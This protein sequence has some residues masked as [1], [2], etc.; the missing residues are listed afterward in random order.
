M[1]FMR[2]AT[3]WMFFDRAVRSL[4]VDDGIRVYEVHPELLFGPLAI[5]AAAPIAALPGS[6]EE[7][8][9]M[10]FGQLVGLAV[11]AGLIALI[12][13]RH[14]DAT[15]SAEVRRSVLFAGVVFLVAWTRLSLRS[16]HLD[17]EIALAAI[18]WALVSVARRRPDATVVLVAIA[19]AVKPWGL[20]AVPLVLVAGTRRRLLRLALVG[21]AV[22]L[23]WAPFVLGAPDTVSS[24]G[25]F[26][27]PVEATSGIATLGFDAA[28][29]PD[30]ARP[31]QLVGGFLLAALAVKRGRWLAAPMVGI[32]VR[33][34][35]DPAT[36][37]YYV[38]G[39]VLAVMAW[40]L[41][42]DAR[43]V[44]WRSV[45]VLVVLEATSG[46]GPALPLGIVRL[47]LLALVAAVG[48]L[49]TERS[50]SERAYAHEPA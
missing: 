8:A 42:R 6:L 18:V 50:D 37:Y 27:S 47:G 9:A 12:R 26:D 30:W 4:F 43:M 39:L 34:A 44:P 14:P 38:I 46:S 24:L 22:A 28:V 48:L 20:V 35:F 23:T 7:L 49:A 29:T 40:E 41:G 33:L 36:H 2:H 32:A 3:S 45:I 15:D 19:A 5:L 17:D 13:A 31:V 21:G 16:A 10:T 25:S 11:V 1:A